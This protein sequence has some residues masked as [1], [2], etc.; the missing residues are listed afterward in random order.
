M[1][2]RKIQHFQQFLAATLAVSSSLGMVAPVLAETAAGQAIKNT[3]TATFKDGEGNSYNSTSNEVVINVA[4]V[5]GITVVAQAPSNVSPKPNDTLYVEFVIT[6]TGNDPTQFFIPGTATLT[7]NNAAAFEQNGKIQIIEVNG[8][9]ITAKDVDTA[10]GFTGDLLGTTGT[11]NGSI[12]S[13]PGTGATGT[14]KV[15]VPIKVIGNSAISGDTLK[16]SLGNTDPID[17]QNVAR[18]DNSNDVYTKDNDNGV[19]GETNATAPKNGVVEAMATSAEI[20]VGARLQAF[21]TVL[22]AVS[23]YNPGANPNSFADDVLTYGLALRVENPVEPP[24]GFVTSDLYG[25]A[26][27]VDSTSKSYVLVSDAIPDKMQLGTVSPA[28]SG[29]QAVYTGDPLTTTAHKA[30]WT[31]NKTNISGK[32]TRV[33]FVYDTTTAPLPKGSVGTGNTISGFSF[34]VTPETGFTGG[35]VANIAQVFG[36]SQPGTSQPGTPTQI[37]YDESGD[38]TSNNGLN[39]KNPDSTTTGGETPANGGITNGKADPKADGTDPNSVGSPTGDTNKGN[40]TVTDP[41]NKKFGGEDTIYT[42][43][44]TPLNGPKDKPAA[45]GLTDN[46]DDFTNKSI[47]ITA[48]KSP[49]DK[50]TGVEGNFNNTMQNTSTSEQEISLL[51]EYGNI[52]DLPDG[53]KVIITDPV[54]ATTATYNF[55]KVASKFE[56]ESG[57]PV[58]ITVA[59][60]SNANYNVTV[61]LAGEVEQLKAFPVV[62]NAFIDVNKDGKPDGEPGN[63]TIDRLYTNYL[64]LLKEARVLEADG[65]TVV[66]DYTIDQTKL[67]T[68][69]TI[70]RIIEYR[71]TYKNISSSGGTDNVI[72]PAKDL[73]IKEDGATAPNTWFGI[74]VDPKY[75]T[76]PKGSANDASKTTV[77]VVSGDIQVYEYTEDIIN[78][79]ASGTFIFQRKIK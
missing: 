43:A 10:G 35:Q 70:G 37:V 74:T 42:I 46:N 19:G 2:T 25:T 18:T 78:P 66:E 31:T 53:T 61:K 27:S 65:T 56:L 71:I 38:Q 68:A 75:P 4:E 23:N 67:S 45:V 1:K 13:Y 72:L 76:Q 8:N 58:K 47:A 16:V 73:K 51:P 7:S 14:I 62:I 48:G 29:W 15:R 54:K 6:N 57:T 79:G 32:I 36:Q 60:G 17:G 30:N 40:D 63:K 39:G 69:A 12:P 3:A 41:D 77:T 20:K 59:A 44:G 21:A 28:P 34:T 50:L 22:K 11:N 9:A 55:N 26:I 52:N 24:S 49:A 5:A 33:G 64:S